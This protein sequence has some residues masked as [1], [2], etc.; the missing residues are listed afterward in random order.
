[1]KTPHS[2]NADRFHLP[3]AQ[4]ERGQMLVIVGV[5]MVALIAMVGLVIDGGL[6]WSQ[7]RASQNGVDAAAHAGAIVILQN[8]IGDPKTTGDV[9]TA[10]EAE[11]GENGV[12]LTE[13]EY[14]DVNGNPLGAITAGDTSAVPSAAQGVRAEGMR[15]HETFFMKVVGITNVTVANDAISVAG[16]VTK[17]ANLMPVTV[18]V[19]FTTCDGQNKAEITTDPWVKNVQYVFPLCGNPT[20]EAGGSYGWIDWYDSGGAPEIW[21]Q[22]CDPNPPTIVMP[23]WYEVVEPGNVNAAKLEDC[24]NDNWAGKLIQIPLFDDKCK[25]K[26]PDG[27]SCT[28]SGSPK[29]YHFPAYAVIRLDWAYINGSNSICNVANGATSCLVGTFVDG[30]IGGT[31][32]GWDDANPATPS[33]AYAVQLID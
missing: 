26:P 23:G 1:M 28:D 13:A 20:G 25:T 19:T 27:E 17:P 15:E 14:T 9:W 12:E 33:Q 18:P 32:G 11:A 16:P 24:F 30:V 22:V 7:N 31:V 5:A 8:R 4:H 29:W 10:V 2:G 6:T 21:E 3:R